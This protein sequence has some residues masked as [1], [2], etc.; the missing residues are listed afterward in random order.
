MP[1]WCHTNMTITGAAEEIARFKQTCLPDGT[2]DFNAIVPM[3]P[4]IDP[5]E[6]SGNP[7]PAWYQWCCDNWGTKWNA[8]D[9]VISRDEPDCLCCD[10][11]TAW[12]PPEPIFIKIG[13]LFPTLKIKLNG[14]SVES[15]FAFEGGIENGKVELREV[16]LIWTMTHPKT[17]ET[18]SGTTDELV[19]LGVFDTQAA[20]AEAADRTD[21]LPF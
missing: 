10:F 13:E 15:D 9:S 18:V 3:P 8:C 17:G 1:N 2:F 4:E 11:A 20:K 6:R 14:S 19:E 21:D 12:C 7:F 16:P 5:H